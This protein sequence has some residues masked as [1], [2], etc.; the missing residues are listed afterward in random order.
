MSCRA[1][2]LDARRP[3]TRAPRLQGAPGAGAVDGEGGG[4]IDATI[5]ATGSLTVDDG[6]VDG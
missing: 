5:T 3:P 6:D 1:P 4:G 2:H